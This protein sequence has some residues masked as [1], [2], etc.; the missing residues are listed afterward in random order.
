MLDRRFARQALLESQNGAVINP[1]Q[2]QG[3]SSKVD[4]PTLVKCIL[5]KFNRPRRRA[6]RAQTLFN[7]AALFVSQTV[8]LFYLNRH[9]EKLATESP[10]HRESKR[11]QRLPGI[12]CNVLRVSVPL[13]QFTLV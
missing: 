5:F 9:F 11:E 13:W 10:R 12:R 7:R 3:A 8:F 1:P 2:A 4:A 6:Q